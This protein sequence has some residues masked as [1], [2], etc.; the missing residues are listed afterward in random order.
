M[1]CRHRTLPPW[2]QRN[3]R[4]DRGPRP[5]TQQVNCWYIDPREVWANGV[6]PPD[7]D[8]PPSPQPS[9]A[10]QA[11]TCL[12]SQPGSYYLCPPPSAANDTGQ[13][14]NRVTHGPPMDDIQSRCSP[15]LTRLEI[16]GEGEQ[17]LKL[18][19]MPSRGNRTSLWKDQTDRP[20]SLS[21]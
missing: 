20:M 12:S 8:A 1:C 13:H 6:W 7:A 17:M 4:R 3:K 5:R 11:R 18:C 14:E 15:Y 9:P 10:G 16:P 19:S 21:V 2:K